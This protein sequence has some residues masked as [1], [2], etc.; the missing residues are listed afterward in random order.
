VNLIF[1]R[2]LDGYLGEGGNG[3][4]S[5]FEGGKDDRKFWASI[6]SLFFLWNFFSIPEIFWIS[7]TFP[8]FSRATEIP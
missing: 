2:N 7:L 5:I 1:F 8:D 6:L 4:L 3:N